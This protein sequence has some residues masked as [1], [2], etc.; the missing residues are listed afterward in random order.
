MLYIDHQPAE[1]IEQ[2]DDR[3]EQIGTRDSI[4]SEI[5]SIDSPPRSMFARIGVMQALN[6]GQFR[7]LNPSRKIITGGVES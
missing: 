1:T 2:I 5:D 4:E 6:R 3:P 7:G